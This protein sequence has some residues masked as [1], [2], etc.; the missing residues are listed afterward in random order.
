MPLNLDPN[1][2]RQGDGLTHCEHHL[3]KKEVIPLQLPP[4]FLK[5][6]RVK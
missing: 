3:K 4:C 2:I 1:E 5:D 6:A